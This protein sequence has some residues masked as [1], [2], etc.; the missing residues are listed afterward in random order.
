MK[1]PTEVVGPAC[2]FDSSDWDV[3]T[4]K[5]PRIT[6]RQTTDGDRN[7]IITEVMRDLLRIIDRVRIQPDL[8]RFELPGLQQPVLRVVNLFAEQ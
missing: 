4:T 1:A 2:R 5:I 7:L 6:M 3:F 8:D